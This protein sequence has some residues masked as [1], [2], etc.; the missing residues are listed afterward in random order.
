MILFGC[1]VTLTIFKEGKMDG[2]ETLVVSKPIT[3]QT[4]ILAKFLYLL[5]IGIVY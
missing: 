2:I 4:I 3:R 5:L 1:M